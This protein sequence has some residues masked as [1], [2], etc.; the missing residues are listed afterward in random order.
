MIKLV[1]KPEGEELYQHGS[2]FYYYNCTHTRA[3]FGYYFSKNKKQ[4]K[5]PHLLNFS[6]QL[7]MKDHIFHW[8]YYLDF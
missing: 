3:F 5:Q 8:H 4:K 2:L 1:L 6:L 7:K